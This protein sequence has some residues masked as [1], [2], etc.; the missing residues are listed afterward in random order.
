MTE[1]AYTTCIR[2]MQTYAAFAFAHSLTKKQIAKLTSVQSLALRLT[3]NARRG[4]P[5][6]GLEIILDVPPI[7]IF[8]GAEAAKSAFRLIGTNYEL[9]AQKGHLAK[10]K[11]KL[12]DLGLLDR[13]PDKIDKL[14]WEKKKSAHLSQN[15]AQ[16]LSKVSD[17][18]R[19]EAK[20]RKA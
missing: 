7:D 11:T 4:T 18:I 17:A 14:L 19:T 10:A 15:T 2:L 8:M 5:P 12:H 13:Q 1:L 20:L 16:T 3:C 6:N 9:S